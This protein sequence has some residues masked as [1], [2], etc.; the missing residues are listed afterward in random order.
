MHIAHFTNTYHPT[1]SGVVRQISALREAHSSMGHNVFIFTQSSDN[2]NDE[3]PFVFRY[4]SF[5][6]HL[7]MSF[8]AVMP[9]SP[10]A[11]KLLPTLKLDIINVH[12]PF[13]L[14]RVG[15]EK[16][17]RLK[18]PLVFTFHTQYWE[19]SHFIPLPQELSKYIIESRL[20]SFL[21]D[22]RHIIVYTENVRDLLAAKYG[23][24]EKISVVPTGI[25]LQPFQNAAGD[26]IRRK[27]GW[28]GDRVMIS[29]GR[30]ALEKNWKT[31]IDAGFQVMQDHSNFRMVLIGDGPQRKELK[32]YVQKLGIVRR[33]EFIGQIP[34]SDV[35]AYLKAAD[36]FGF[37]SVTEIIGRVNLEA[38]AA[39]LPVVA[40]DAMGARDIIR[41]GREGLLTDNNSESLADAIR[42]LLDN[43]DLFQKFKKASL[44]RSHSF[45]VRDEA[46]NT[47]EVYYNA[48][49]QFC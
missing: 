11:D 24:G 22:C 34:F 27:R 18:I 44:L 42:T 46:Q 13:L 21:Q 19:H 47:L 12:H 3:N 16:A 36:F 10:F 40:V 9:I 41:N 37:A 28:N 31:L 48:I 38:I 30:L 15:I 45:D 6:L 43:D 32:R 39:G 17:K 49:E 14:G 25:D 4:P 1:V 7:P 20:R 26:E 23:I 8:P 33:V 2:Y 5:G 29:I 35:P